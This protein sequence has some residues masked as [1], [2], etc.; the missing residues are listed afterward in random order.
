[1]MMYNVYTSQV[2]P[3]VKD[4][5]LHLYSQDLGEHG[6]APRKVAPTED[7]ASALKKRHIAEIVG[8]GIIPGASP[9]GDIIIPA[10]YV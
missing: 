3:R 1:M 2:K 6:I 5:C 9:L 8:D 4:I 10:K 7:F